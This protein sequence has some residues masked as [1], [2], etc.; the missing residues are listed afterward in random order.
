MEEERRVLRFRISIFIIYTIFTCILPLDYAIE[1]Y[2]S[3]Y[4][5]ILDGPNNCLNSLKNNILRFIY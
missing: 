5:S 4:V 1:A 3:L 2:T